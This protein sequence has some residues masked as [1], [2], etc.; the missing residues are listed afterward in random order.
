M[1]PTEHGIS[2]EKENKG[3]K[4]YIKYRTYLVSPAQSTDATPSTDRVLPLANHL[5]RGGIHRSRLRNVTVSRKDLLGGCITV[6]YGNL[7]IADGSSDHLA[8]DHLQPSFRARPLS[9]LSFLPLSWTL[10]FSLNLPP[11]VCPTVSRSSLFSSYLPFHIL[12]LYS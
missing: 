9:F 6:R 11:F 4:Q 12:H 10:I 5:Q 8:S 7:R 1:R 2:P 3:S